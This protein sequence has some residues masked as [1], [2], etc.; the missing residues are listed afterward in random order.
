MQSSQSFLL[1]GVAIGFVS[2]VDDV[3]CYFL[4]PVAERQRIEEGASKIL[5]KKL[6]MTGNARLRWSV[7]QGTQEEASRSSM[8]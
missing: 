5:A 6:Q 3:L 2:S 7:L 4:I 1:N 8:K